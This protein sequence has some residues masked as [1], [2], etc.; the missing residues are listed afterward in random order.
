MRA[1]TKAASADRAT[2]VKVAMAAMTMLLKSSVQNA[3]DWSTVM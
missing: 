1:K 3:S 2:A